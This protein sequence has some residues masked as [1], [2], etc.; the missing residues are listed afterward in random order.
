MEYFPWDDLG[1]VRRGIFIEKV[2]CVKNLNKCLYGHQEEN[3]KKKI[4][5]KTKNKKSGRYVVYLYR[6]WERRWGIFLF[7]YFFF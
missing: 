6:I 4:I 2:K 7:I 3:L 1:E 5:I